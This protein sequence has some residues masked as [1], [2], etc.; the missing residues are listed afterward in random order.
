MA[1]AV[2]EI[3]QY[4]EAIRITTEESE[5]SRKLE[6]MELMLSTHQSII[7]HA[8]K[9]T[10][11]KQKTITRTVTVPKTKTIKRYINMPAPQQD[12][13]PEPKSLQPIKP[14]PPLGNQQDNQ[15]NVQ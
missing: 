2:T 4:L 6:I 3:Q 7:A 9:L 8:R 14:R 13:K 11:P 5:W 12:D 10:E 15:I 1:D